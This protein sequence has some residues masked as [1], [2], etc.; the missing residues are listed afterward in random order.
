MGQ[1][2]MKWDDE[3][4][5]TASTTYRQFKLIATALN[6]NMSDACLKAIEEFVI[7]HQS[8]LTDLTYKVPSK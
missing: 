1:V 6:I 2:N 3:L 4:N 5:P 8:V 7:T